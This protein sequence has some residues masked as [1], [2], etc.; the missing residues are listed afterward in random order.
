VKKIAV[1]GAVLA[2][3]VMTVGASVA[4][5]EEP[6]NCA[7]AITTL[8]RADADHRAAV[9]ADN[10]AAAA[11]KADD[12]VDRARDRLA[13]AQLDLD[14]ANRRLNDVKADAI[15]STGPDGATISDAEQSLID[16]AQDRANDAKG[17][18][19]DRQ[20]ELNDAIDLE[21]DAD[22]DALQDEADKTDAA[23]LKK[24]LDDA[25]ADFNRIC[26]DEDDPTDD[27]TT[28]PVTPAPAPEIT[29]V[30]PQGGV[31]TGGGPA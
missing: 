16:T 18:R 11:E 31:S 3:L 20:E 7:D 29:V 28:T 8:Q 13:D 9:D 2:G 25:R 5:A 4:Y 6:A 21:N 24:A 15:D 22:A 27:V 19:D 30:V 12:A 1:A 17:V 26:I 23:A 14:D 10:K